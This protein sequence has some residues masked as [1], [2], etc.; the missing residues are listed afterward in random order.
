M[1]PD[2]IK[3][4]V[5]NERTS[6][7]LF[8]DLSKVHYQF[9]E[10]QNAF[11]NF[12]IAYAVKANPLEPII[13]ILNKQNSYFEVASTHEIQDLLNKNISSDKIIYSNP[14]KSISSIKTSLK[15][16]VDRHVFDSI[17]ELE[18]YSHFKQTKLFFRISVPNHKSMIALGQKFG[19]AEKNWVEILN[20][21]RKIGLE[22]YGI[23][24]HVGSQCKSLHTWE[25]AIQVVGKFM[26]LAQQ[27]SMYPK[28]L[29]IGGGF[30]IYLGKQV[31]NIK[32]IAKVIYDSLEKLKKHHI[33]FKEFYAEPGR[34]L[35]APSGTLQVE[36]IGISK[37]KNMK[38]I[39]LNCGIFHGLMEVKEGI[40]YPVFFTG[41]N[42]IEKV[43]LCGPTCDSADV[44]YSISIPLP[45]IGDHI[46]LTGVGAY[47][48]VYSTSFNGI[49]APKIHFINNNS[50]K[51]VEY[52]CQ[53]S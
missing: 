33:Y 27:Y 53:D 24:F 17:Y 6:V 42:K 22:I 38:W 35:V 16:N 10:F 14:V 43:M 49:Q 52:L 48:N 19:C 47:T 4:I 1:F 25:L 23:T 18:K 26:R 31:P 13:K 7:N 12:R 34:F 9:Q 20:Y 40:R 36:V 41:K 32:S 30:P 2:S 11:S 50:A 8:I 44:L 28:A 21:S 29:N 37:R 51:I 45:N 5:Q 3:K 39:F 15:Q 46:Y